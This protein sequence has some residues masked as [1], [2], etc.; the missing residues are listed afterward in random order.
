MVKYR[1]IRACFFHSR[2]WAPDQILELAKGEEVP[3][4]F[5]LAKDEVV[6]EQEKQEDPNTFFDVQKQQAREVLKGED[7]LK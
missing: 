7:F 1:C 5:V 4:H 2:L 6:D 3:R